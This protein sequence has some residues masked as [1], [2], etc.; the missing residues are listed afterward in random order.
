MHCCSLLAA[1]L[2]CLPL[3]GHAQAGPPAA[4]FY[5]GAG[6]SLFSNVPFNEAGWSRRVGPALTA[7]VQLTP[8]LAVQTGVSYYRAKTNEV[9]QHRIAGQARLVTDSISA[10]YKSFVVPLLLRYTF[11]PVAG[12]FH[13]DALA[14]GT[15]LIVRGRSY[16]A[17]DIFGMPYVDE[18]QGSAARGSLALGP[19]VR[20]AIAPHV[21]LTA[22]ATVSTLLGNTYDQFKNRLFLNTLL[23]ASYTF[24]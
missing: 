23:G 15:L 3:L 13:V 20:Y 12:K 16:Y 7:G 11:T 24:G 10:D 2:A 6:A 22:N 17:N 1:G 5:V 21:E 9:F 4:R 8:R 14:G 19:A 18:Y